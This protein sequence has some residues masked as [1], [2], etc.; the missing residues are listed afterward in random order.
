MKKYLILIAFLFIFGVCNVE[1]LEIPVNSYIIGEYLFTREGSQLYNGQLST[2]YIMLASKSID[3]DDLNDMVI[4]FK[5]GESEYINGAT[6][7]KIEVQYENELADKIK[8]YNMMRIPSVMP[9]LSRSFTVNEDGQPADK[10]SYNFNHTV[11]DSDMNNNLDVSFDYY[12]FDNLED[13]NQSVFVPNPDTISEDD[14]MTKLTDNY[15]EFDSGAKDKYTIV[16]YPYVNVSN[17]NGEQQKVYLNSDSSNVFAFNTDLKVTGTVENGKMKVSVV[18]SEGNKYKLNSAVLYRKLEENEPQH[19]DVFDLVNIYKQ[20]DELKSLYDNNTY[21]ALNYVKKYYGFLDSYELVDAYSLITNELDNMPTEI[22]L[23]DL[24]NSENDSTGDYVVV[25]T[26]YDDTNRY[27]VQSDII[28]NR[29]STNFVNQLTIDDNY[30]NDNT[31][32]DLLRVIVMYNSLM[33]RN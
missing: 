27:N 10:V 21:G 28:S 13:G 2:D 9:F 4:Y 14:E 29:G 24:G 8:Y 20:N 12:R 3:S 7:E 18:D 5:I 30:I 16:A 33:S 15:L 1:A 26:A 22:E 25:A 32:L 11:I 6:G 31:G 17:R 23:Y 19:F